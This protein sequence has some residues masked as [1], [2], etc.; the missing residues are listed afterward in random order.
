[1]SLT[2]WDGHAS[3]TLRGELN[4]GSAV[5]VRRVLN[6][7]LMDRGSVVVDVSAL[8]VGASSS[9]AVFPSV[10]LAA[11]GWPAARMVLAGPDEPTREVLRAAGVQVTVPLARTRDDALTLLRIRPERV[12]RRHDMPVAAAAGLLA[13]SLLLDACRDWDI[14]EASRR[15]EIVGTELVTNAVE[16]ART[17]SV[18]TTAISP[19]GLH[20]SVRDL[21]PTSPEELRGYGDPGGAGRGLILV[22]GLS[23]SWGITRHP[24]GKTVWAVLPTGGDPA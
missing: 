18:L 20:I 4:L 1:M 21:A 9:V 5:E 15:A 11:G 14:E 10:L 19:V 12:T 7:L 17:R 2:E 13:R 6:K 16:H 24:N 23:T 8:T 22:E 3:V